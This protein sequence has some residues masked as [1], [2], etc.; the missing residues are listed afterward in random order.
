M[1]NSGLVLGVHMSLYHR[2][3]YGAD[4]WSFHD[5]AAVLV[6]DEGSVIAAIEEER[7][8]RIKHSNFFPVESIRFCLK[9]AGIG[10]DDVAEIA[11]SMSRKGYSHLAT[12]MVLMNPEQKHLEN[13]E[14]LISQQ[15]QKHF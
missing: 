2:S 15:F 10:L 14:E 8:D 11:V 6:S 4:S 12:S 5:T 1:Q 3:E 9:Q 13:P 7:L